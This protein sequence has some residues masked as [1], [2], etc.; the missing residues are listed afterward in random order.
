MEKTNHIPTFKIDNYLFNKKVDANIA[1][2]HNS[3]VFKRNYLKDSIFVYDENENLIFHIKKSSNVPKQFIVMGANNENEHSSILFENEQSSILFENGL[4]KITI[5]NNKHN[6][7]GGKKYSIHDTVKIKDIGYINYK[8]GLIKD[9]WTFYSNN[10][11][12]IGKMNDFF[13][14]P[15]KFDSLLEKLESEFIDFLLS[16]IG[17]GSWLTP[18]NF[19]I[20]SCDGVIVAKIK[21]KFNP[22]TF[23]YKTTLT[24]LQSNPS[25]D[26]RL[27][28][29]T[30][31][32]IIGI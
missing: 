28:I 9:E 4:L 13:S 26:Q 22:F 12:K 20:I 7:I 21:K 30:G 1:F 17:I 24:I 19:K 23:K 16:V 11:Q 10:N 31:I 2:Q 5:D 15:Y 14:H 18:Q 25:I 8:I 32:L 3:Y 6:I 27:L 29:A